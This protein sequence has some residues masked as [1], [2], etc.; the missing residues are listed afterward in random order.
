MKLFPAF[1]SSPVP[2]RVCKLQTLLR[3][4]GR[5]GLHTLVSRLAA[6]S[7]QRLKVR[8][9]L[10]RFKN[11]RYSQCL[12]N[13]SGGDWTLGKLL[14]STRWQPFCLANSFSLQCSLLAVFGKLLGGDGGA[15]GKLLDSTRFL[16]F[17]FRSLTTGR[18]AALFSQTLD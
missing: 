9:T 3:G 1:A 18:R 10:S 5:Y 8:K 6:N 2:R 11:V 7:S 16:T 15:L 13:S 17:F 12:A 4:G 14:D